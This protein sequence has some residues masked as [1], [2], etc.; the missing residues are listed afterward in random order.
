VEWSKEK[1]KRV[2]LS[3]GRRLLRCCGCMRCHS[4]RGGVMG[5]VKVE[6]SIPFFILMM[7]FFFSNSFI[8]FD[9][10]DEDNK[11][12]RNASM[13]IFFFFYLFLKKEETFDLL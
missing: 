12:K 2:G 13:N 8:A 4:I 1:E 6:E 5:H 10:R 7:I 9:Y 3:N 11:N